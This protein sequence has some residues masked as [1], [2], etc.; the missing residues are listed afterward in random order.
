M[1]LTYSERM[2]Y[3]NDLVAV[4]DDGCTTAEGHLLA[5]ELVEC[6]RSHEARFGT[7]RA[8]MRT[9]ESWWRQEAVRW[10]SG[11]DDELAKTLPVFP[12]AKGRIL[13]ARVVRAN[14]KER[15][16]FKISINADWTNDQRSATQA[17]ERYCYGALWMADQERQR[18]ALGQ[19]QPTLAWNGAVRGVAVAIPFVRKSK[20]QNDGD[21]YGDLEPYVLRTP[22]PYTCVWD[23]G[24]YG[25]TFFA[26]MD[27]RPQSDFYGM[28]EL[29]G[30]SPSGKDR[31]AG[32]CET[33]NV[34]WCDADRNVWNATIVEGCFL[35][36]P[37][38]HTKARG[39]KRLPVIVDTPAF[40][41]PKEAFIA[42]SDEI[43]LADHYQGVLQNNVNSYA[44]EAYIDAINMR[45]M[46]KSAQTILVTAAD[47][48]LTAEEL[49]NAAQGDVIVQL[50][51]D[52]RLYEVAPPQLSDSLVR[53]K[54]ELD[55]RQQLGGMPNT[56]VAGIE[57]GMTGVAIQEALLQGD[58]VA[59]PVSDM[60]RRM[61]EEIAHCLIAQHRALGRKIKL[62]GIDKGR[63]LFSI[64]V[65]AGSLPSAEDYILE[66]VH[67]PALVRDGYRD[68][69]E[70]NAWRAAGRAWEAI[71][72]EK[73][74]DPER[75]V[76]LS[77]Q[78]KLRAIPEVQI[79]TALQEAITL[80]GRDSQPAKVM[81]L[82]LKQRM[83]QIV[84][85]SG[86]TNAPA[87]GAPMDAAPLPQ[88][89]GGPA[90]IT[91]AGVNPTEP[92]AQ[93]QLGQMGAE[94]GGSY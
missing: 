41:S 4:D 40:G 80:Y 24:S 66:A 76:R 56:A 39:L 67:K 29:A 3:P 58:F 6:A 61:H 77:D 43:S 64:G 11:R 94:L 48:S 49:Q 20:R 93:E 15:V 71:A 62:K 52:G 70:A 13:A 9:Y 47:K 85:D 51:R 22:D 63:G 14:V 69:Q 60:L 37:T 25:L 57:S 44:V 73:F 68:A 45:L 91:P 75:E 12:N 84:T 16:G 78:E 1:A 53:W 18:R 83:E 17:L 19:L 2:M 8:Q 90:S 30:I 36:P 5:K 31:Y 50:G 79:A 65:D 59:G 32:Y 26:S 72:D 35:I 21:V 10:S 7:L 82:F 87:A 74:P 89:P 54:A 42:Q 34:W 33:T 38:N 86:R 46:Q 23:E 28:T 92:I 88:L 27:W 81:A 55:A